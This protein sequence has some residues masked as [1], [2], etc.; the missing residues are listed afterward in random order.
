MRFR[1]TISQ[2]AP[3]Y[4]TADPYSVL[5]TSK[6]TKTAGIYTIFLAN[7]I[8]YGSKQWNEL[9][10]YDVTI[11]N[12]CLMTELY[13]KETAIEPIEYAVG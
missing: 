6:N 2:G 13:T 10:S 4:P 7:T 5:V 12:P 1:W 8:V 3:I 11:I 9:V